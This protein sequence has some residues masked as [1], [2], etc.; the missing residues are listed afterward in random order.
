MADDLLGNITIWFDLIG[1]LSNAT[2][3]ISHILRVLARI[4]IDEWVNPMPPKSSHEQGFGYLQHESNN[5]PTWSSL[6]G[7]W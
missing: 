1:P 4:A 7:R 5:E 2:L 6:Y 3:E